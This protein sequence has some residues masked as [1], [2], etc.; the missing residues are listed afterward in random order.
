MLTAVGS[1]CAAVTPSDGSVASRAAEVVPSGFMGKIREVIVVL[2]PL[3]L[4]PLRAR[5]P[6]TLPNQN[7]PRSGMGPLPLNPSTVCRD[8]PR[9]A[10]PALLN[11]SLALSQS[12]RCCT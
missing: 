10:L 3:V 5:K 4:T 2:E 1:T 12:L 7:P 11:H 6:C 9:F 8:F